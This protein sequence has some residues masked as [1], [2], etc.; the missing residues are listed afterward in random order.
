MHLNIIGLD[1]MFGGKL[2]GG[3]L[4]KLSR[5]LSNTGLFATR[6]PFVLTVKSL[7]IHDAFCT[8]LGRQ[9]LICISMFVSNFSKS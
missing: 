6:L 9:M 5:F 1:K 2:N 7:F 8:L 3:M 4:E